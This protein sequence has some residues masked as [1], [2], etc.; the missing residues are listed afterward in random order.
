MNLTTE[1]ERSPDQ[2]FRQIRDLFVD[3]GLLGK[4]ISIQHEG[5]FYRVSCDDSAFMVYRVN[6]VQRLRHHLP[7][8]PVCLVNSHIIFEESGTP[9]LGQDHFACGVELDRWLE[10]V[11]EYCLNPL[12]P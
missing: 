12:H 10:M 4:A 11:R 9:D 5:S 8:W 3:I 2:V 1:L 7:G 6:E